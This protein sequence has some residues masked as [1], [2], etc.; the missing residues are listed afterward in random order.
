MPRAFVAVL[1]DEAIRRSVATQ[2]DRLRPL[3]K[4]GAA[5]QLVACAPFVNVDPHRRERVA[6]IAEELARRAPASVLA[7]SL[8]GG[9]WSIL[10]RD[11]S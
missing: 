3:S 5:A 11:P 4:A 1:L 2:I 7:F 10:R 9:F 8:A 6:A